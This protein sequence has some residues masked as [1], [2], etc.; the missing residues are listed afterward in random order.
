MCPR[1]VLSFKQE[2]NA[3]CGKLRIAGYKQTMLRMRR[4]IVVGLQVTKFQHI[5]V[6]RSALSVQCC[7]RRT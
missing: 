7:G 4:C 3:L 6:Q 2:T 5:M 1:G